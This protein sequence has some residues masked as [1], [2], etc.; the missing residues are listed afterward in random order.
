VQIRA[1]GPFSAEGSKYSKILLNGFPVL[2]IHVASIP[3]KLAV[4]LNYSFGFIADFEIS[5]HFQKQGPFRIF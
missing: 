3:S 2:I 1:R 4:K 5:S